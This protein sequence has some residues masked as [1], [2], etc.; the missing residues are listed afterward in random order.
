MMLQIVPVARLEAFRAL[1]L[2]RLETFRALK[3][4]GQVGALRGLKLFNLENI[5][6]LKGSKLAPKTLKAWR[7]LGPY[8]SPDWR[9]LGPKISTC[10]RY[11]PKCEKAEETS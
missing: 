8:N 1:K 6:A 5:S 10:A 4:F 3:S 7:L 9:V 2:S 11:G